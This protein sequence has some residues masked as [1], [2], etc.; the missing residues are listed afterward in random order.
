VVIRV[1][2]LGSME[3]IGYA[4]T[5]ANEQVRYNKAEP[6]LWRPQGDDGSGTEHT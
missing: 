6:V 2:T 3:Q 1:L 4:W 5:E